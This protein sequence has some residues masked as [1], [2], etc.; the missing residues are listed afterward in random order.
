MVKY[1]NNHHGFV[2][3]YDIYEE[4]I[5]FE[6]QKICINSINNFNMSL[7]PVIYSDE[8]YG[9]IKFAEFYITSMAIEF[10]KF[11]NEIR[12]KF[13]YFLNVKFKFDREIIALIK[14]NATSTI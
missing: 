14:K 12:M 3:E 10:L 9:E 6:K 11:P 4:H 8:K 5:L 1:A 13:I 2:L 7:Y